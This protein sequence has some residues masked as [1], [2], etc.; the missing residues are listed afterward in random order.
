MMT[1]NVL[2]SAAAEPWWQ[3]LCIGLAVV[4]IGIA[5][6]G[7]GGGIGIICVPLMIV[8]MPAQ[9]ALGVMLPVLI[10]ADILSLLHHRGRQSKSHVRWLV[11]GVAFGII[12]ATFVLIAF[13]KS[14]SMEMLLNLTIG[15]I[16]LVFVLIQCYRLLGGAVPRI[17][18]TAPAGRTVG[19]LAGFTST[20]THAAGPIIS[21]YLL[22]LRMD[23]QRLVGT[24][25]YYFFF[26]NLLKLPTYLALSL[27]D[28]NTAAESLWCLPLVPVG[29]LL[30]VWM[31]KRVP[32]K[33]FAAIIYLGAA[34]AAGWMIYKAVA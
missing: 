24:S 4:L 6:A 17:P 7:F 33:P 30:G 31:H 29:T 26:G 16:C 5:K 10:F 13:Q 11:T 20:L 32:E 18:P 1:W 25:V 27:I 19:V 21:I 2:A 28:W 23:K 9:R 14:H 34:A 12:L 8:A 3:W 22:E 15:S